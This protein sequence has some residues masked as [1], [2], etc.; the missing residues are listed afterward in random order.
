MLNQLNFQ[1]EEENLILLGRENEN[2]NFEKE[3]LKQIQM[4]A[5]SQTQQTTLAAYRTKHFIEVK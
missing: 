3:R 4:A 5:Q 1:K 2:A